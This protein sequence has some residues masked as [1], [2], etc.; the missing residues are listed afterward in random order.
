M[1]QGLL[2]MAGSY[3]IFLIANQCKVSFTQEKNKAGIMLDIEV[4]QKYSWPI[5]PC[6]DALL[7]LETPELLHK[8]CLM[9]VTFSGPPTQ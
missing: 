8:A 6:G 1:L 5:S 2:C 7:D 3:R 9:D 4:T